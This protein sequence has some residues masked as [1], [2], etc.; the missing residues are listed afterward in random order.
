VPVRLH[1]QKLC[2]H[3]RIKRRLAHRALNTAQA[4]HL[5]GVQSQSGHFQILSADVLDNIVNRS[6]GD[7]LHKGCDGVC[8]CADAHANSRVKLRTVRSTRGE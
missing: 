2:V 8:E 7:L 3:Q 6:H 1:A 5:H 4:L